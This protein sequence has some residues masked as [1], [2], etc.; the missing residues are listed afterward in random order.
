MEP[1]IILALT[2]TAAAIYF[3]ISLLIAAA[4]G[5]LTSYYYY[6]SIYMKKIH[7]LEDDLESR[8]KEIA[9]LNYNIA[10]LEV[11]LRNKEEECIK[12]ST[13]IKEAKSGI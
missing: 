13:R 3:V 6:K 4:I 10:G 9:K 11:K 12:L 2:K 7:A 1:L 5:Y 8:K